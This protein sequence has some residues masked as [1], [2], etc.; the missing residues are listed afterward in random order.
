M[1]RRC[2]STL[3]FYVVVMHCGSALWFGV[4]VLCCGSALLLLFIVEVAWCGSV[5]V[6]DDARTIDK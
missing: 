2:G 1:V 3:R 6:D 5:G 4:V